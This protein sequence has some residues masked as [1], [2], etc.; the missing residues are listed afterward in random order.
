MAFILFIEN[1]LGYDYIFMMKM[2]VSSQPSI[3]NPLMFFVEP[4]EVGCL[5][6]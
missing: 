6:Q 5:L 1:R 2:S 4:F 3:C